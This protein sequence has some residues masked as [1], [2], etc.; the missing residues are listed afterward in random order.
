VKKISWILG[1]ALL[2]CSLPGIGQSSKPWEQIPVPKLHDF[3]PQQPKRVV[4]SNGI[5]LLL[6]EDHE[7]PVVR[8][9]FE[10]RGGSRDEDAAKAGLVDLYG[11]AWRMSGTS[12]H[13]GD[14]LDDLLESKA[15]KIETGGDVDSTSLAWDCLK[16][17]FDEVLSLSID[18]LLHPAFKDQKLQLAKEQEAT[19]IVRR[20]DD[21]ADVASRE[22]EKLVYGANS[23]YVRQPEFSTIMPITVADLEA[24][25]KKTLVPNNIIIGVEGDFDAAE[26]QRK[27][28]EALGSLPKGPAWKTVDP[29]FEGPTP[30][31]YFVDK[32]DVN[33]S[34]V[35]IVGLGTLRSNPDYPALTVMNT[36]LG[37]GFGSRLFQQV[38]TRLGY[39]YEVGGAFGASYD[40]PGMF[41]AV[42]ATKS[43]TTTD[44]IQ[45]VLEQLNGMK[46]QPVTEDE[47]TKAKDYILNSFIFQYDSKGKILDARARLEFYGYPADYLETFHQAIE[48][49]TIADVERVAKKYIDT[50][51]MA[52]L[53]VGNSTEIKPPLSKLG[54]V[55]PID[56]TI[57]MPAG[58]GGKGN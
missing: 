9:F 3:K 50:D 15:A 26:V 19:G 46:S 38:R 28:E 5:V 47:L 33:Q 4:L 14:A 12:T 35:R 25:H 1:A 39:A 23:P 10:I 55:H 54:A 24:W 52:T 27:L 57:P 29:K 37:G 17:D 58:M 22:A 20:N 53:V 45:A 48:K 41:Y 36:I 30:G 51:K 31:L 13:D 56:V 6:Q 34:N 40:H 43:E 49:I 8:G 18:L 11:A 7:L 2:A 42:A 21:A 16:S 44:A 32:Q